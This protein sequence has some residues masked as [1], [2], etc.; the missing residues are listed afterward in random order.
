MTSINEI[1]A[2]PSMR[3]HCF[4]HAAAMIRGVD[5]IKIRSIYY[6]AFGIVAEV[7]DLQAGADEEK[8][9]RMTLQPMEK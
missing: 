4:E 3:S 8:F 1:P 7:E 9:Y 2:M 5:R 6:N